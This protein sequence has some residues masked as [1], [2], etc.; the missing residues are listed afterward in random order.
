[1]SAT[2]ATATPTESGIGL[3]QAVDIARQYLQEL[4][5]ADAHDLRLEET[6]LVENRDQ[7]LITYSLNRQGV[8]MRVEVYG[9][10]MFQPAT[11]P[12]HRD[13]KEVRIDAHSGKVKSMKIRRL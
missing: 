2:E 1:M 4:F 12:L 5:P 6:E 8:P 13:Y 7:W 3:Q 10:T 9:P 11:V